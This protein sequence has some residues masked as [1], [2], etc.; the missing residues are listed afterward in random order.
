MPWRLVLPPAVEASGGGDGGEGG[1]EGDSEGV[2]VVGVVVDLDGLAG[3]AFSKEKYRTT[4]HD[5]ESILNAP[6]LHRHVRLGPHSS[7]K[8]SSQHNSRHHA[9]PHSIIP[10]LA[11]PLAAALPTFARRGWCARRSYPRGRRCR[12]CPHAS[13]PAQS[14]RTS[15]PRG[16]RCRSRASR[17]AACQSC[18]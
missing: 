4:Q 6:T 12:R 1:G 10:L 5:V 8:L 17:P 3:R 13:P 16:S 14:G 18:R 11:V 2:V 15:S 7:E 9:R